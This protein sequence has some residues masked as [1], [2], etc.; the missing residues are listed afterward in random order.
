VFFAAIDSNFLLGKNYSFLGELFL[1]QLI[2]SYVLTVNDRIRDTMDLVCSCRF[3]LS[4][5]TYCH[6]FTRSLRQLK[7]TT[8]IIL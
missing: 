1:L 4:M 8:T 5:Q 7:M 3:A 2:G 6:R